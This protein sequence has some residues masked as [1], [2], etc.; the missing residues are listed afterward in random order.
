M[1]LS[2][3]T[4]EKIRTEIS[5]YPH[6]RGALLYAL[7]MARDEVGALG[8]EIFAEVGTHFGMRAGEVA[9]VASFY[10]LFNQP[11]AEASIQVCTGLPCCLNGARGLVREAEKRLGTKSGT[12]TADGRF[13]IVEVECLGS[14]GT[15][16]VIQVNRNPY[17][18]R[19]TPDYLA[20]ILTSP[21][22]AIDA[23]PPTPQISRIPEGI[24][25]Y[26]L[27]PNGRQ[28]LTIDEYKQAGGYL[29]VEKAGA[30]EPK[31]IAAVVKDAGLRG[32]GG[33]GFATGLKW[34]FMPPPDGGPR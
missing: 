31:D 25:G 10:S 33:A 28:R 21:Q 16:P 11:K 3:A 1:L 32:R 29:A 26:L 22:G 17:I 8:K 18:E 19:A 13:A 30:M 12:A 20:S 5:H 7:H 24:D 9:E 27:P 4:H 34:T 14:C 6:A 23:R 2:A 15:A